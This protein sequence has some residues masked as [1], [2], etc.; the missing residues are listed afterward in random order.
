VTAKLSVSAVGVEM[1]AGT[2]LPITVSRQDHLNN[3]VTA[4]SETFYLYSDSLSPA[5]KFYTAAVGGIITPTVLISNGSSSATVWYYD[6]K[7]GIPN[8]FA[9]D[10]SGG[11]DGAAG[12]EDGSLSVTVTS[13]PA[14]ALLINDA[15]D[16]VAGQRLQY[17]LTRQ[18]QFGNPSDN[19]SLTVYLTHTSLPSTVFYTA[20]SGGAVISSLVM[21]AGISTSS[22]WLYAEKAGSLSVTASDNS[23]GPD[24]AAGIVDASDSLIVSPG[25]V[26]ILSL[27]DPGDMTVGT[28]LG[29]TVSRFDSYNN[30]ATSGPLTVYLYS[31]PISV[32]TVFYNA[33]SGGSTITS[34][35]I[36]DGFSTKDFWLYSEEA[37]NYTI[38]ASDNSGAPDGPAGLVDATDAVVVSIS[39]IVA[40]RFVIS[41]TSSTT[42]GDT[43]T[44]S[45]RAE[46]APGNLDTSYNSSVTLH[47]G[48]NATPGGIVTIANGVGSINI[49]DLKAE[50]VSLT[51][52]DTAPT[53]LDVSS[54]KT[55]TFV[56]GPTASFTI[57]GPSSSSAG[58][59]VGYVI[60]RKDQYDNVVVSGIDP[61]HL[62]TNA[63]VGTANFYNAASGGSQITSTSILNGLSSV[64]I[65]FAGTK[66]GSWTIDASDNPTSPDAG[67]GI[68]DGTATINISPGL[69]A[70]LTLN[71]PGDMA[72]DTRLGYI[73]T[74]YDAYNNPVTAGTANYYLYSN[75]NGT[76]TA[77]YA[78]AGG[79][80]PITVLSFSDTQSTADF[81]YY[82]NK[83]GIWTVYVSD[84]SSHPDG[85]AGLVDGEDSVTVSSASIVATKFIISITGNS[86][87]VGT[88]ITVTVRAVDN[89]NDIDTTYQHDVTLV[90]SG[91]AIGG[92]LVDIV[93]G[94]GQMTINDNVE[95]T[96]SLSLIDSEVTGLNVSSVQSIAFTKVAVIFGG[97][98]GLAAPTIT[99]TVTFAGQAFPQAD[100]EIMAIQNGQVPIGSSSKGSTSGNF[101][102]NYKGK[103]PST[104]NSF[105]LVVYDKDQN[106]A[107]TKIFTLGVNDQLIKTI[108]MSPTIS[109]KQ[110]T[111]TQGTFMGLTGSAM[112]NYKIEMM[113][114]GGLSS[115][116]AIADSSGNYD[117]VFNTYNL[118]LGE[119]TLR[120]RQVDSRGKASDYSIEKTFSVVKTFI[121]KADLNGD[122]KVDIQDLSIFIARY[123]SAD[124]KNRQ[125]LDLNGDGKVDI[126]DVSLFIN[127]LTTNP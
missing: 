7:V 35:D 94:V 12:I 78:I 84:N 61:V 101:N 30:P 77:F 126:Q 50:T 6:E 80:L 117:L 51:L 81:W 15:G 87:L 123:R 54:T 79:G 40:T 36:A 92:G 17:D 106:I 82:E 52:E 114:D 127:A 122:G 18:D 65:W 72:A 95:E 13:A 43:A 73:A 45:V 97:G 3:L 21:S 31:N 39:P 55:I 111:V 108:L 24:G 14:A 125:E 103:L 74:R 37:N 32:T 89:N 86:T 22:F 115:E 57:T 109:L 16:L 42:V 100:V 23:G 38:T 102:V 76:A 26:A 48:G 27:N 56:P 2:R 93:N 11:T 5:K 112:P 19:G 119:H 121:P 83:V 98:S 85:A 71:D 118:S 28:R 9:S 62:Y 20:A 124:A 4:G 66:A 53:G 8:L 120:V 10:N 64:N 68:I 90:T 46:D 58:E 116:T 99:P 59:R 29:Y 104:A 105:A 107:Q 25:P 1:V 67:A 96:V 33:D 75:A 41:D 88:P 113:I 110:Q 44:I 49:I 70:R 91:S 34:V 47:A 63:V 60:S 69:S